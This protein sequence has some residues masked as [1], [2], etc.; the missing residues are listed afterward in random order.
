MHKILCLLQPLYGSQSG[1]RTT[2]T[3]YVRKLI[4]VRQQIQNMWRK[5]F[6]LVCT[7][8]EV[9]EA[10]PMI[11]NECL[12]ILNSKVKSTGYSHSALKTLKNLR[13]N[14]SCTINAYQ[15]ACPCTLWHILLVLPY[16]LIDG[17]NP[18]LAFFFLLLFIN[19]DAFHLHCRFCELKMFVETTIQLIS[20]CLAG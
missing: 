4:L 8:T 3:V 14:P 6:E 18:S 15:R 20:F 17:I 12:A 2:A 11:G 1:D 16:W 13:A 7:I 10:W 19:T 9:G 5:T